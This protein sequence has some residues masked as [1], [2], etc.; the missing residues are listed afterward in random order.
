MWHPARAGLA[1]SSTR[2]VVLDFDH[3]APE[4]VAEF[5]VSEDAEFLAIHPT[6]EEC[7][8]VRQGL[9][10]ILDR[11]GKLKRPSIQIANVGD[12]RYAAWSRNG[13]VLWVGTQVGNEQNVLSIVGRQ[14]LEILGSVAIEGIEQSGHIVRVH[15]SG[16]AAV[17]DVS[18]GQDGTWA[19]AVH[20]TNS[21]SVRLGQ[22]I[23]SPD[24]PFAMSEFDPTGR[25]IAAVTS[26]WIR[27]YSWPALEPVA[28][29]SVDEEEFGSM[30]YLVEL[31]AERLRVVVNCGSDWQVMDFSVP[32]LV[33]KRTIDLGI[34]EKTTYGVHLLPHDH[35]VSWKSV[36]CRSFFG[37][38]KG[39]A[40]N[41]RLLKVGV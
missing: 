34:D 3:Q 14:R 8:F 17:V 2:V 37:K 6:L 18:C 39:T 21:G 38:P 29:F 35:F 31:T 19:S 4:Q 25:F 36:D 11:V 23:E 22:C 10:T 41:Y 33:K 12:F 5:T 28:E 27:L 30:D 32:D 16:E 7:A 9:L 40:M 13:D 26:A 20:V 24:D 1:L 15:P